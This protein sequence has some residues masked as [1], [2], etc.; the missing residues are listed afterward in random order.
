MLWAGRLWKPFPPIIRCL[1]QSRKRDVCLAIVWDIFGKMEAKEDAILVILVIPSQ[2]RKR[3]NLKPVV[4]AMREII[5][6][7][8]VLGLNIMPFVAGAGVAGIAIGF[9]AKDTLSN[10]I[11]G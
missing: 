2:R 11:A 6:T 7:L 8:D 4:H 5:L 3:V 1:K 9:A 10:W